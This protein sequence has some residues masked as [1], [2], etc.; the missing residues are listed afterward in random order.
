MLYNTIQCYI[1]VH[2][3]C[4]GMYNKIYN[5]SLYYVHTVVYIWIESTILAISD[6]SAIFRGCETHMG[7]KITPWIRDNLP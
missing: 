4:T 7:P 1:Y 2:V 6:L 5:I 3:L